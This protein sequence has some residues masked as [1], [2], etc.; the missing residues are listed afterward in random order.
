MGYDLTFHGRLERS[1]F[2]GWFS[3]RAWYRLDGD[4]ARFRNDDTGTE[5]TF[6]RR[7]EQTIFNINLLRP[8]TFALEAEPELAAF[9]QA[10]QL[11]LQQ[12]EEGQQPQGQQP[13]GQQPQG[14]QPQG[15]QPPWSRER[16]LAAWHAANLKACRSALRDSPAAVARVL[17]AA[18][19]QARWRW[20]LAL[21]SLQ[22][23]LAQRV[24]VPR[25]QVLELSGALRTA[26]IW[27]DAIPMVLP[28]VEMLVLVRDELA[29]MGRPR[30]DFALADWAEVE[31]LLGQFER[32]D[33]PRVQFLVRPPTE[34]LV[35]F[36][37]GRQALLGRPV[38]VPPEQI[39]DAELVQE[40]RGP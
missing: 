39:L 8:G 30:P 17:P 35:S 26:V 2:I 7:G 25:I 15:Q 31:P 23:R 16:F 4:L 37:V 21:S 29:G 27:G 13:Q 18:E 34:E 12:P 14:Q 11:R 32:F 28:E 22:A 19:Q 6:E 24:Y 1:R 9:A 33:E 3:E 20:N 36:F 40:A 38:L 10:F 5:F